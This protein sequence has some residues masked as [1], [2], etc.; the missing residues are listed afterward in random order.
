MKWPRSSFI[1]LSVCMESS[2]I[3]GWLRVWYIAV[4]HRLELIEEHILFIRDVGISHSIGSI[5]F[6]TSVSETTSSFFR[7][8]PSNSLSEK[9]DGDSHGISCVRLLSE[10]LSELVIRRRLLERG[11]YAIMSQQHRKIELSKSC[12]RRSKRSGSPCGVNRARSPG[13]YHAC[14]LR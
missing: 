12:S 9:S 14:V 7:W 11:Y 13:Y 4:D 2:I 8:I 1:L 3:E 6:I 10:E 5:V